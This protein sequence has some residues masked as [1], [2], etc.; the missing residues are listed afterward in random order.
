MLGAKTTVRG[1]I[2][3]TP[4]AA[5]AHCS[6]T[7]ETSISADLLRTDCIT[8]GKFG[9]LVLYSVHVFLIYIPTDIDLGGLFPITKKV[10][11]SDPR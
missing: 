5:V 9:T 10:Y 2:Y 4:D 3:G 1:F 6:P 7:N 8:V 11:G